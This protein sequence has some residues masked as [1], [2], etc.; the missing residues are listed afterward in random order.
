MND[1]FIER[2]G[3]R[4]LT[5]S[6]FLKV[7]AGNYAAFPD[8]VYDFAILECF[9][10]VGNDEKS[11]LLLQIANR[12]HDGLLR[13]RIQRTRCFVEDNKAWIVIEGPA[14]PT[15]CLWPPLSRVPRSPIMVSKAKGSPRANSPRLASSRHC[16]T[17]SSSIFS[18]S[19]PKAYA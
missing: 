3:D 16:Q 4:G 5:I 1:D 10:P 18:D 8:P 9:H 14:I 6:H 13:L 15:R 17:L 11:P 2:I 12:L 19:I 7:A